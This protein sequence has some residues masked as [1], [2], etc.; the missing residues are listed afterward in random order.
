MLRQRSLPAAPAA[1]NLRMDLLLLRHAPAADRS[2]W[3][4][5]DADRPLTPAGERKAQRVF[6]L[7]RPLVKAEAVWT[8]PWVRARDTAVIASELWCLPLRTQAWLAGGAATPAESLRHLIGAGDVVLVG[9]QPDLGELAGVLLGAPALALRKAGCAW[10]RGEP[11]PGGMALR[12]LLS[13]K[14]VLALAG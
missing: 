2:D 9:H 10:L 11:E 4:G 7:L 3:T 12:A 1:Q 13:P 6:R 14:I 8:S 5:A